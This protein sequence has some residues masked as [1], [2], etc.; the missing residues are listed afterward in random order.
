MYTLYI[1]TPQKSSVTCTFMFTVNFFAQL[2]IMDRTC[3]QCGKTFRD[4][5][6]LKRHSIKKLPCAVKVEPIVG[7]KHPCPKCNRDFTTE[8][9]KYRHIRNNCRVQS[10]DTTTSAIEQLAAKV[11]S[12]ER[13]LHAQSEAAPT[14]INTINNVANTTVNHVSVKI[15]T[16]GTPLQLTDGDVEAALATVPGF[17]GTPALPEVVAALMELVKRAHVPSAARNVHLNPKRTDQALALT[18]GGWA[19]MPLEEATA[20]LFD[21]ASAS[22]AASRMPSVRQM[23]RVSIPVQYRAE[24]ADAVQLGLRPMGAHLLNVA[25]G[26][27]GP[28]LLTGP[29][30]PT[31][32]A[33]AAEPAAQTTS[34][35]FDAIRACELLKSHPAVAGVTAEW[36]TRITTAAGVSAMGLARALRSASAAGLCGMAEWQGILRLQRDATAALATC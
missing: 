21:G 23:M 20:A 24:R 30:A 8:T 26:G 10:T 18:T 1:I 12:L 29:A 11:H 13:Q 32:A 9:A 15:A 2:S 16:W 4:P 28:L 27:P 22:M 34:S 17:A 31:G 19:A 14:V 3:L 33:A 36:L 25:P 5:A 35:A 7:A 6:S